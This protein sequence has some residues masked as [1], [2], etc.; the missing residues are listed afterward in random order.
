VVA[1]IGSTYFHFRGGKLYDQVLARYLG[2]A[3]AH[4]VCGVAVLSGGRGESRP[5]TVDLAPSA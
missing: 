1:E 4:G 5:A 2:R 3:F